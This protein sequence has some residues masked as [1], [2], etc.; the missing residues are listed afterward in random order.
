MKNLCGQDF[1]TGPFDECLKCPYLGNGCSGPRTTCMT[2]ERYVEWLRALKKLRN[3]TNQDISDGTGLSK[4]TVDDIFAGRRKDISRATAGLLEDFLIGV[5]K[6]PCA[7]KLAEGKEIIYEDRPETI[8][9]LRVRSEQYE[10]LNNEYREARERF[11]REFER[12][13]AE[14]EEEKKFYK[15]RMEFLTNQIRNKDAQIARK[16]VY[17]DL[18][19]ETAKRGGD[20]K[21]LLIP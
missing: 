3:Y 17:I 14:H 8:D 16:D 1:I 19:I 5:G 6:W 12:F 7:M 10:S 15:E 2:H 21:S 18:L 13:R 20:L 4:A 9:A 11:E